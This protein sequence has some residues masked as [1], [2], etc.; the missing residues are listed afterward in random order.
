MAWP[1]RQGDSSRVVVEIVAGF[2]VDAPNPD[3]GERSVRVQYSKGD[4]PEVDP[5]TAKSWKEKGLARDLVETTNSA[6]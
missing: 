6:K 2:H 1:P 5:D 3:G 4:K